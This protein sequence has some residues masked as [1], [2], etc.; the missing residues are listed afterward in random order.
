MDAENCQCGHR[1]KEHG[2]VLEA[3]GRGIVLDTNNI[4]QGKGTTEGYE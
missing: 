2:A 3:L 1:R 4:K